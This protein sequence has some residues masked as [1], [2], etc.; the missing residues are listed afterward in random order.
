MLKITVLIATR[1]RLKKLINTLST[2]PICDYIDVLLVCDGCQETYDYFSGKEEE[3]IRCEII[4]H[5]GSVR[6]RN[7]GCSLVEDGLLYAVDDVLF[8]KGSIQNAFFI[9]NELFKDDDGLLGFRQE[10]GFQVGV[11]LA[12]SRFVDRFPGRK[13]FCPKYY[14]FAAQELRWA[15]DEWQRSEGRKLF[16]Y[17]TNCRL[18]H[19]HS[20]RS[21]DRTHIE[22]RSRFRK[23]HELIRYR[24]RNRL[25]WG[26]T[27]F[28][29]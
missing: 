27:D 14:H 29:L 6:A 24:K 10:S 9:F 2:I 8:E 20:S 16:H 17:A 22:A 1:G 21:K 5:Q 26:V 25:I 3:G 28:E 18:R 19:L 13:M 12:G 11:G 23:D 4:P 7:Y 15:V